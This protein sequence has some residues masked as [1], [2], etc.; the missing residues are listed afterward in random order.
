MKLNVI[1]ISMITKVEL[2]FRQMRIIVCIAQNFIFGN[3]LVKPLC[4]ERK[5]G[6]MLTENRIK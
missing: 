2:L 5:R 1:E 3:M 4:K 6:K